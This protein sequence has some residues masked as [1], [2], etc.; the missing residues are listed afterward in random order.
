MVVKI[1]PPAPSCSSAV[2]YNEKK[3]AEGKAEAVFSSNIANPKKPMESFSIYERGSRRCEKMSFH[4]SI[5]PAKADNMTQEKVIA[6]TKELMERL[7]YGDQPYIIY[8]H[9]DIDRVH[10]HLVSVRV[11]SWSRNMDSRSDWPINRRRKV[12][13]RKPGLKMLRIWGRQKRKTMV[14]RKSNTSASIRLG[15]NI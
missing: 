12:R 2:Q 9:D 10:Y 14:R 6:F 13:Q 11:E 15:G 5:N 7:G 1:K 4:A 8:R 3:I